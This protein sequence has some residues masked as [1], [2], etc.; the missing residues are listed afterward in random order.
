MQN[1][2]EKW[3]LIGA[4][5]GLGFSLAQWLMENKHVAAENILVIGRSTMPNTA[6]PFYACDL[7]NSDNWPS[8]IE[9]ITLFSAQRIIYF[10]GGGPFGQYGDK[11]FKDHQWAWNVTY[12]A[13]AYLLHAM[14]KKK[15][16]A[17]ATAS[18][19]ARQIIAIGS[20]VAERAADPGAA[21][22]SAA[23]H[24][25]KGLIQSVQ[26]ELAQMTSAKSS[27]DA[28]GGVVMDLRLF[29]PGYMQTGMLPK[30]AWPYQFPNMVKDSSHVASELGEWALNPSEHGKNRVLAVYPKS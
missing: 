28:S 23:K 29:S 10:A 7:S 25:L 19:T 11:N 8:L 15:S 30:Q 1:T 17:A 26:V 6:I 5:K 18:V 27:L 22:Y 13:F 24:A 12:M 9:R 21:S 3:V 2:G 20:A 4:T 14:L 16:T